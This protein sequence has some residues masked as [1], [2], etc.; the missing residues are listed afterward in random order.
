MLGG[1]PGPAV[2]TLY[3]KYKGIPT[4]HTTRTYSYSDSEMSISQPHQASV[5]QK[6]LQKL[7][8]LTDCSR[9]T[10]IMGQLCENPLASG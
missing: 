5:V 6:S 1:S 3:Y 4:T 10:S 9:S 8:T 7:L 2:A